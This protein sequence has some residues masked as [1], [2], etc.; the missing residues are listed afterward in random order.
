MLQNIRLYTHSLKEEWLVI[1]LDVS[2][3]LEEIVIAVNEEIYLLFLR[4]LAMLKGWN[5][6]VE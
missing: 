2:V 1:I 6:V 3:A 5:I 4:I